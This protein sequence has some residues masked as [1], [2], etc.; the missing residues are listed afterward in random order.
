[1]IA[2]RPALVVIAGLVASCHASYAQLVGYSPGSEV[3]DYASTCPA[4]HSRL[5]ARHHLV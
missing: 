3:T 2:T 5:R 1:M 4:T